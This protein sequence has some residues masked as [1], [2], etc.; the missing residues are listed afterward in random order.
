MFN[1]F[2]F[3]GSKI[4]KDAEEERKLLSHPYVGSEHL[5]L[6]ILKNN[7]EIKDRLEEIGLTYKKFKQELIDIV[8]IPKKNIDV[9][10]YTPLLK[11]VLSNALSDAKENN[12]GVVTESHLLLAMLEEGEG[13]A[14]RIMIGMN[15]NLDDLYDELKIKPQNIKGEKLEVMTVGRVLNDLTNNFDKVI[16]RDKEI[17]SV[18]E[19]LM[20]KKKCNPLLIGPAGVGKTAIVEELARRIKNKEVPMILLNKKII[21]LNFSAKKELLNEYNYEI[22]ELFNCCKKKLIEFTNTQEYKKVLN[23]M[24]LE[25]MKNLEDKKDLT[26][27]IVKNDKDKIDFSAYGKLEILE[28]SYIGGVKLQSKNILVDNT[29]LTN[30]KEKI[31]GTKKSN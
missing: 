20:R 14:I 16:G 19:V 10:L 7:S 12:K 8:G 22:D 23:N 21:D 17:N 29:I 24:F 2:G 1:N 26:I 28:D 6:A 30:L 5:L 4:L 3:I 31:Y 15:I 9:N 13:I 11:R 27:Y 25:A 18:I